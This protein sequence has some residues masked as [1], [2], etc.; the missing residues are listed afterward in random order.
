[1]VDEP[2]TRARALPQVIEAQDGDDVTFTPGSVPVSFQTW[3]NNEGLKDTF[4]VWQEMIAAR[5]M[6]MNRARLLM[7][8]VRESTT[9]TSPMGSTIVKRAVSALKKNGI[10]SI[11]SQTF[12]EIITIATT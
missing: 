3:Q 12:A 8:T 9:G 5:V 10:P 11:V 6:V 7:P 4:T 2:V 1:M